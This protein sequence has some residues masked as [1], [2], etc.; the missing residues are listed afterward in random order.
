M[1]GSYHYHCKDTPEY[2]EGYSVGCV[3]DNP[4]KSDTIEWLNWY[5]GAS[6]YE[7]DYCCWLSRMMSW[8]HSPKTYNDFLR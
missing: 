7:K 8:D 5:I 3:S 2:Q 6:D 4:H 1:K